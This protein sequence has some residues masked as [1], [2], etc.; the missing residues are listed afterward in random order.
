MAEKKLSEELRHCLDGNGCVNCTCYEQKSVLTCR[1][2][3]QKA[4]EVVKSYEGMYEVMRT[5]AEKLHEY[6]VLEEQ[7]LLLKPKCVPGDYVWET[8]AERNIISEYEVSSIRYGINK[9][10]HYMLALRDGIYGELDGFW[11]KDIGK[12]VFLSKEAAEKALKEM[13][14]RKNGEID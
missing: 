1:V 9:T 2:L 11:D 10:F 8:N 14:D 7:G 5:L 6:T 12:T 3:L 4:Y 13:E